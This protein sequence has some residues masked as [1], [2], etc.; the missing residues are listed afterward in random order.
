MDAHTAKPVEREPDMPALDKAFPFSGAHA[1]SALILAILKKLD[2]ETHVI[3]EGSSEDP[4]VQRMA[5]GLG[6]RNVHFNPRG[7][8]LGWAMPLATGIALTTGKHAVC[9]VGDGGSMFSIHTIWTAAAYKIPVIFVCFINHEYHPLKELW[10][11]QL[12]STIER[13]K[14]VGMDIANPHLGM[15]EIARG[16]GAQVAH[17]HSPHDVEKTLASAF[18]YQGPSFILINRER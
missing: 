13:T 18:H 7:G 6:I 3:T 12:G 15:E 5:N 1:S 4:I 17:I 8:G 16:F 11:Q 9:F 14:F 10:V 2:K